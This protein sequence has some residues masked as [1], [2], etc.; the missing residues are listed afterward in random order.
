MPDPYPAAYR[1]LISR[2]DAEDAHVAAV[3]AIGLAGRL[4]PARR[5]LAATLGRRPAVPVAP[6]PHGPL[7]RQV[8]SVVGL[9][10]GMDK[11]GR[12]VLGL[13]ALG[14]GFVEV[15]TVTAHPQPGNPRPRAWRHPELHALRNAMGFN[16]LGADALAARLRELRSTRRGRGV[17]VGVNIGKSKVVPVDDAAHD[18][19]RSARVL[20]RWADYLVVNVSSPNT[21]GLRSLQS[22]EQLRPI[23]RGVRAVADDAADR[24]VP[25]LVKIA[26]DLADQ[27]VDAVAD[28]AGD[29][30]LAG[31]SATNTTIDHDLGPGGLSGAPLTLRS[32]AVVARLRDRLGPGPTIIGTG[33]IGSVD[34]ARAMLGAGADLIQVYS[35][36]VEQGPLLPGRLS[37][38]V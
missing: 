16:N 33:G 36:F 1:H 2:I 14:F 28:L 10:A 22:V 31:V 12:A 9:A 32:R 26:P 19:E 20:A 4:E 5:L 27:D 23:L 21:P 3:R 25:L 34:D 13:D 15:G 35:A 18:Y 11:D 38:L 37:R 30:D 6:A 7:A 24:R 29:L 8:P 17:V